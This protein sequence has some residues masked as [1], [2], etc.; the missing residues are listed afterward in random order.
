[1][2]TLQEM[3]EQ[4]LALGSL[5]PIMLNSA[6]GCD[7]VA[8]FIALTMHRKMEKAQEWLRRTIATSTQP[9]MP[10]LTILHWSA[11]CNLAME[12]DDPG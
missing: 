7:Q 3:G 8:T 1:M 4:S 12:Q 5:V 11:V 10:D 6:D 9:P 2:T